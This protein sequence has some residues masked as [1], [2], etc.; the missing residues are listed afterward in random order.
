M[1]IY[2]EIQNTNNIKRA[3]E[4]KGRATKAALLD[5][6]EKADKIRQLGKSQDEIT[7]KELQVLITP[8]KR[9][10]DLKVPTKKAELIARLREWEARGAVEVEEEV[11]IVVAN[12]AT[13]IR[14]E[15]NASSTALL[16]DEPGIVEEV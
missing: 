3:A 1:C 8:L 13:E 7:V 15:S 11:A 16:E 12:A 6:I 9:D 5:K 2:V 4:E 14:N 10:G